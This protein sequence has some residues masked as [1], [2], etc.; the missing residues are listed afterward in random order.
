MLLFG[1]SQSGKTHTLQGKTGMQRGVVPR[2]VEDVL[3][4]LKN[5]LDHPANSSIEDY[6][7]VSNRIVSINNTGFK[8]KVE[9]D[10]DANSDKIYLKMGVYMIYCDQIFDLLASNGKKVKIEHY[11]DKES[12]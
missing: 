10:P 11:I 9:I 1:P 5:S 12:Q 3:S 4:I 8:K 6:G 2:A 7:S